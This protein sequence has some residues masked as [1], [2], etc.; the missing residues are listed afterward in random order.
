MKSRKV[1]ITALVLAVVMLLGVVGGVMILPAFAMTE[2]EI[3]A[4]LDRLEK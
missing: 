4:E 3:Q 2:Q 1:K